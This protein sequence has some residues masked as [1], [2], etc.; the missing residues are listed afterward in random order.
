MI[1]NCLTFNMPDSHVYIEG[2]KLYLIGIWV[3]EIFRQDIEK[4]TEE[5]MV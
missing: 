3:F 5:N 2:K 1:I 4:L